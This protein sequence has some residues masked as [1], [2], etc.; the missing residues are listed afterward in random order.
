MKFIR[1]LLGMASH[2]D[3]FGDLEKHSI[4]IPKI[5]SD[6]TMQCLGT[7]M[8]A[9]M[10]RDYIKANEQWLG[11]GDYIMMGVTDMNSD[12]AEMA[13]CK[14]KRDAD[15][16][17]V[18]TISNDFTKCGTRVE[19][20]T[21]KK[22]GQD[23]VTDYVFVN[24]IVND[25]DAGGFSM[26][27]RTLD[28]LEFRCQYPTVQW[29]TGE[30]NPLV[31]SALAKS[32]TKEIKGDMRLY[33]SANYTDFY[34][35]P[36]VLGLDEIL[37]VEVNLERPLVSEAFAAS[38]DFAVV[39]EHCWGT[40]TNN[41]Q[42]DMKYYIIKNQCPVRGDPSLQVEANGDSLT[43]R[44]NIKMFKF[45]GD[46]L[47]DV[48]MHCTVRACNTTAASCVP[49]CNTDGDR[50]RRAVN[51]RE[52]PFVSLGHEV[53]SELPIQRRQAIVDDEIFIV[54]QRSNSA[55]LTPGT[56][57]FNV[58][59]IVIAVVVMLVFVFA[60]TCMIQKRRRGGK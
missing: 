54:E 52:L 1:C 23:V 6:I 37:Y 50:K 18:L 19:A 14:G 57:S 41:R 60:L 58:M 39:L 26:V 59:M 40:P 11:N 16:N 32:K 49:D 20:M 28:I 24:H 34:T 29:E 44:F 7:E 4:S 12:P 21:E 35:D 48:W 27:N 56:T 36:P 31:Q 17:I 55:P 45:I 22:D 25:V 46:D 13:E 47:N 8:I 33:K 3:A 38:T 42:G 30:I 43:G 5:G 15:G 9:T 2:I 51:R 53:Q 10:T